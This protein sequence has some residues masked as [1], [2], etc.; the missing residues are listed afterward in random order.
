MQMCLKYIYKSHING[1]RQ[2]WTISQKTSVTTVVQPSKTVGKQTH[3]RGFGRRTAHVGVSDPVHR[4]HHNRA[5]GGGGGEGGKPPPKIDRR[6]PGVIFPP[7]L[8][9]HLINRSILSA[10]LRTSGLWCCSWKETP[11]H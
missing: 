9:N 10:G 4:C 6:S 7:P 2:E 1:S 5:E 3:S 8:C 11:R